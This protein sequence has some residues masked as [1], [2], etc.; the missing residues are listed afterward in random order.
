MNTSYGLEKVTALDKIINN[1]YSNIAGMVVL[2]DGKTLY[3]KYFNECTVT[4]RIHVYSVTKSILSILIGIAIDKGYIK[5]INQKILDFFPDYIIKRG[6][7]TIQNVT[8]KN[9]LTMTAPYKYKFAPYIKYFT[10]DDGVKF[11]LD[12]LGGKGQIGEFRYTPLIGPDILSGILV[13]ATG[14]S[15]LEFATEHLFLPLGI[16]ALSNVTFHSK[17]EQLAFNKA[18]NISGWVADGAGTNTAGWGLTLSPTD[19]AKIG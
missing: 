7:K 4:S 11:T 13:K 8:L 14:Q 2:K 5:S 12:L 3:E 9:L 10:S 15:V 6:E 1:D 17:E 18:K 16:S 19:M